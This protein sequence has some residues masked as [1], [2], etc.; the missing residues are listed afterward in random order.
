MGNSKNGFLEHFRTLTTLWC[1]RSGL[2]AYNGVALNILT[3]IDLIDASED[4]KEKKNALMILE[5]CMPKVLEDPKPSQP[6]VKRVLSL[7]P[8]KKK[9]LQIFSSSSAKVKRISKP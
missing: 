1:T 7:F 2:F 8:F 3:A 9:N 6:R 5:S 4:Q